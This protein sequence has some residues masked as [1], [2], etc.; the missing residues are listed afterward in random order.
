MRWAR[1]HDGLEGILSR[2]A[3]LDGLDKG[4]CSVAIA[5]DQDLHVRQ[6]SSEH[7]NK[8]LVGVPLLTRFTGFPVFHR[9]GIPKVLGYHVSALK[10]DGTW[11]RILDVYQVR[12]TCPV[13]T[14]D[15][16]YE[17]VQ[18]TIYD[19]QGIFF[20]C[21]CAVLLGCVLS[22]TERHSVVSKG[23]KYEETKFARGFCE[24][25]GQLSHRL[26]KSSKTKKQFAGS[27]IS[28]QPVRTKTIVEERN[29]PADG[30]SPKH[31]AG[32]LDDPEYHHPPLQYP[33]SHTALAD[34]SQPQLG[35]SKDAHSSVLLEV[36][37]VTRIRGD[38]DQTV[39]QD[40]LETASH[41][42]SPMA[43]AKDTQVGRL[44]GD[45]ERQDTISRTWA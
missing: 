26:S 33:W 1:D 3:N 4:V 6:V 8:T 25:K 37:Q 34:S 30:A 23:I 15:D 5:Q 41:V 36:S 12:S 38:Q 9:N 10:D 42:A 7:C 43:G 24:K 21:G 19:L 22:L 20:V 17:Y 16:D 39:P 28:Q 45:N 2:T 13:E 31:V 11:G 32:A 44:W 27:G 35:G 14:K 29:E 40:M 18:L